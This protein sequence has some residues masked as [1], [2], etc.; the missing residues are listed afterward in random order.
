M[1]AVPIS[2]RLVFAPTAASCQPLEPALNVAALDQSFDRL[3]RPVLP[4]HSNEYRRV[5]SPAPSNVPL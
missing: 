2:I 1:T 3:D 5:V 4:T